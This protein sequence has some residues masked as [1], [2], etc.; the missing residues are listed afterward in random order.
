MSLARAVFTSVNA[1]TLTGFP[2]SVGLEDFDEE[3]ALGPAV[4]L[5]LMAG[6]ALFSLIGG[7]IAAVRV[8]QLPYSDT[9]V[10]SAAVASLAIAV[11]AGAAALLS[12]ER[13]LFDSVFQA[14]SAFTNSGLY[15]G[16]LPGVSSV[17]AQAVL[18]PLAFLGGLGL[19]V[20]MDLFD[21][22]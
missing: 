4:V 22:R 10:I 17:R 18:M 6:G 1:A 15:T 2:S 11:V 7:G 8:L 12:P 5:A 19:P 16:R 13:R 20:L 3:G 21:R 14:A 9:Q